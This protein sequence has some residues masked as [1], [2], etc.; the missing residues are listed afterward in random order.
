MFT[1]A[2][3]NADALAAETDWRCSFALALEANSTQSASSVRAVRGT[4]RRGRKGLFSSGGTGAQDG[5]AGQDG[6]RWTDTRAPTIAER[7]LRFERSANRKVHRARSWRVRHSSLL[8]RTSVAG[9]AAD[10]LGGDHEQLNRLE[11]PALRLPAHRPADRACECARGP[12][13]AACVRME[14]RMPALQPARACRSA[15]R[16]RQQGVDARAVLMGDDRPRALLERP[17][18]ILKAPAE[19]GVAARADPLGEAADVV[20][21]LAAN[22]QVGGDAH[23]LVRVCEEQLAGQQTAGRGG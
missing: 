4:G 5:E 19:V 16:L 15:R 14:A 11:R 1:L 8:R 10:V 21:G 20:E 13:A 18:D 6:P 12:P 23:R 7:A 17:A 2:P 9:Q 3:R 22:E